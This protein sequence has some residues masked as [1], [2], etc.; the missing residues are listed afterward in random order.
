MSKLF[1]FISYWCRRENWRQWWEYR[2]TLPM[3]W[4]RARGRTPPEGCELD[5]FQWEIFSDSVFMDM[6]WDDFCKVRPHESFLIA[7]IRRGRLR[8]GG[9]LVKAAVAGLC[10]GAGSALFSS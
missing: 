10:A 9:W 3:M 1:R 5:S 2:A 7:I 8:M 6:S 4:F